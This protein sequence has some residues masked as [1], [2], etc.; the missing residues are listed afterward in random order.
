MLNRCPNCQAYYR[1][2][3]QSA[4]GYHEADKYCWQC[5]VA[6]PWTERR[7]AAINELIDEL[8]ERFPDELPE[9]LAEQLKEFVPDLIAESPRVENAALHFGTALKKLGN[10]GEKV[11][12][13]ALV[14]VVTD[15][16]AE[17]LGLNGR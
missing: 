8:Q 2:H 3:H 15:K 4:S 17:L 1:G 12:V 10:V 14:K 6:L 13:G 16:A 5:G 7:S 11:L 9:A